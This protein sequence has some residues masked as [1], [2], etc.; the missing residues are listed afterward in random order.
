[1]SGW[2]KL[3]RKIQDHWVWD[4]PE[5]LKA[6][7][8]MLFMARWKDTKKSMVDKKGIYILDYGD[9]LASERFFC[10][11]WDWSR[12]KV[13]RFL[14]LCQKEGQISYK[15]KDSK[16]TII[17]IVNMRVYADQETSKSTS[18]DTSKEP[19]Q[20]QSCTSEGPK[21]KKVKNSKKGEE[22]KK[23]KTI[24]PETEN[25]IFN[26]ATIKAI[27]KKGLTEDESQ[28]LLH[29]C[30]DYYRANGKMMKD[31]Q[32]VFRNWIAKDWVKPKN[33]AQGNKTNWEGIG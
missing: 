9:L 17:H 10:K 13:R 22:G 6:W 31:W 27:E 32:A 26:E 3:F 12:S 24:P 16:R 19:V 18:D 11:R 30:F 14:E 15:E 5:Y 23:G 33:S 25:F 7:L 8:D 28:N 2:I 20:D 1:M 29:E 21:K 4:N